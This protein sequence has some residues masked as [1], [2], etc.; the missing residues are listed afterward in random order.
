MWPYRHRGASVLMKGGVVQGVA[1]MTNVLVVVA[2]RHGGTRGIAD[3]IAKTLEIEGVHV[4]VVSPAAAKDIA[5][6]D[7]VIVGSGVY[8]GSWLHEALAFLEG[9]APALAMRPVWFFSSGPLRGSK[10]EKAGSALEDA[11]GPADGPGSAGR[12]KVEAFQ[13][14]VR[15][16]GHR[17]FYGA[18]D[19]Y[20]PPKAMSERLV[21][22]M[23]AMKGVLPPGRAR[24]PAS[25]RPNCGVLSP[26][27]RSRFAGGCG[28]AATSRPGPASPAKRPVTSVGSVN[29]DDVRARADTLGNALIAGDVDAAIGFLS[30]E[31]RRNLGEVV[32]LLPLPATEVRIEAIDRTSSGYAVV[33]DVVGETDEVRLQ[34]RWKDR[35]GTPTIVEVS[36]LS[37]T[38]REAELAAEVEPD[39][40]AGGAGAGSEPVPA[41]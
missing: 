20:D 19:P 26:P 13:A 38:V 9:N 1:D 25:S 5:L 10:A 8:M 14:A 18:F 4:A 34:T 7:A 31:L 27:G 11:L 35:A 32:A 37:R 3:R 6:S 2:S 12:K 29:E 40:E 17:I 30:D 36:H 24:S 23:P 28:A 39:A 21:R 22:L 41:A 15:A 33:L 16:R